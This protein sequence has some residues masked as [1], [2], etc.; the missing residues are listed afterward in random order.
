MNKTK[1][2]FTSKDYISGDGMLTT[3]WGP[4]LW[5]YLH[6]MSFN[7]PNN[8]TLQEKQYYK[9]FVLNLQNVLLVALVQVKP[10]NMKINYLS[11][12]KI[13]KLKK[14]KKKKVA[15]CHSMGKKPNVLLILFRKNK[16]LIHLIL[17]SNVLKREIKIF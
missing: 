15:Q 6:V 3:V 4:S 7:Y 14:L 8:P 2:V 17:I 1:K 9:N 12:L 5:H 11:L 13:K 10:L 16:K